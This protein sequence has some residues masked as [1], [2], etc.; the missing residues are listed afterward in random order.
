MSSV[1]DTGK[2]RVVPTMVVVLVLASASACLAT[3]TKNS[4]TGKPPMSEGIERAK[5]AFREYAGRVLNV[6]SASIEVGSIQDSLSVLGKSADLPEAVIGN[7]WAFYASKES[8]PEATIRGWALPDGSVITSDHNLGLLLREAAI[9]TSKPTLG[10]DQ[11]VDQIAWSMGTESAIGRDFE[12]VEK[13]ARPSINLAKNGTGAIRFFA[14]YQ[15][16]GGPYRGGPS[17]HYECTL[18]IS[19]NHEAV[20]EKVEK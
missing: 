5:S 16:A 7:A 2:S 10:V 4:S 11:L 8:H 12:V 15:A 17:R 20:L 6:P 19:A 3:P 9:G 13:P 1:I 14:Q 18:K